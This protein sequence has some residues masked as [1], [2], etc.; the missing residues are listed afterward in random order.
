MFTETEVAARVASELALYDRV[1]PA[2]VVTG[3]SLTVPLSTRI[4]RVP[5]VWVI[6]STW[7]QELSFGMIPSTLWTPLKP[8]ARQIIGAALTIF[9]RL[10]LFNP[11][12]RVA[13]R[14]GVAPISNMFD[15]W[16]GDETLLAEPPEFCR[17]MQLPPHHQYIGPLIAHED[18]PVPP[19][20]QQI[21]R[22]LPLIYFAMGSS[23]TPEIIAGILQ[24]FGGAPYRVIAPVKAHLEKLNVSLPNNVIVTDWLPAQK[25]NALANISV[26]HGGIGTVMTAALAGKPVV[27][28]G[29]QAEQNANLDCLVRKGFAVRIAKRKADASHILTAVEQLLSDETVKQ[30]ARAFSAVVAQWDGPTRAAHFLA[31]KYGGRP[32]S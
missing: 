27:G 15:L 26:I 8:V 5:L 31:E 29:M 7:L 1:Q 25:V 10:T 21:P 13:K 18:F 23:G 6:Q 32:S 19:A 9:T 28:V 11:M 16:R 12:N 30:K 4:R 22:D 14:Y 24:G 17:G 3:W 2:A 20:V